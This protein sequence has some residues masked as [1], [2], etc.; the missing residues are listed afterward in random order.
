MTIAQYCQKMKVTFFQLKQNE[1]HPTQISY[2]IF[3]CTVFLKFTVVFR[4]YFG[5]EKK[6]SDKK[7]TTVVTPPARPPAPPATGP[8]PYKEVITSKAKSKT[9][10]FKVHQIENKFFYEIP[11]SL[12]GKDMLIITTIVK[13]ADGIGYG[14]ERTNTLLIYGTSPMTGPIE[15]VAATRVVT[16][17]GRIRFAPLSQMNFYSIQKVGATT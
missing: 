11:E 14:G 7:S 6:K 12:L 3:F 10:L 13:T 15:M 4:R 16:I 1:Q 17:E 9:G 8:K 5:T 2:E